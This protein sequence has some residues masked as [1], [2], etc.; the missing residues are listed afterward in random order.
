MSNLTINLDGHKAK[1]MPGHL[2]FE[3]T[4]KYF[5]FWTR[6]LMLKMLPLPDSTA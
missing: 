4:S 2:F 1:G 6:D 5:H 3:I